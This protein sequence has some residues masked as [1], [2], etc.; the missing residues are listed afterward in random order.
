MSSYGN[1]ESR[2]VNDLMQVIYDSGVRATTASSIAITGLNGDVDKEYQL[3]SKNVQGYS[4][5]SGVYVDFNGD[6]GANYGY[7]YIMGLSS[8][9]SAGRA[10]DQNNL[11]NICF[12]RAL[13]D[14]SLSETNI[15][16]KSGNVRT[17]INK[18][19][20]GADVTTIT[21]ISMWGYA[22]SDT[23][24]NIA[25]IDIT[26]QPGGIGVG[27]HYILLRKVSATDGTQY[28]NMN[29]KGIM[30]YAWQE[31]YKTTLTS[32]AN[33]VAISG[34][35]GNNDVLYRF[36]A[37]VKTIGSGN[38][39]NL[40]FYPNGD[41]T[42]ANYGCQLLYGN[43]SSALALRYTNSYWYLCSAATN[44]QAS[45]HCEN[46]FYA[47]NGYVRLMIN[48]CA[49]TI[50]GTYVDTGMLISNAWA[51]T[52]N[53]VT[54]ILIQDVA[55]GIFGIGSYFCLERLNL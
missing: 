25:S 22:Y 17:A 35:N 13:G 45:A 14:S 44:T 53:N 50:A 9:S 15:Y 27:S 5:A 47:K 2:N 29:V 1:I 23:T 31:V 40:D 10:T 33:S 32:T 26:A 46:I 42:A 18:L 3:I 43:D 37:N 11:I 34:L 41:T 38:G 12:N 21:S 8:N 36:T 54:S 51:D 49:G 4:G 7:Q 48:T 16:S 20:D 28:G 55:S 19:L 30:K 52:T 39:V 24:N 6:T